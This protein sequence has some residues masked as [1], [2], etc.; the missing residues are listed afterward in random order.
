[1]KKYLL[2]GA[3]AVVVLG[4]GSAWA[5]AGYAAKSGDTTL[6]QARYD[7][8]Q[9]TQQTAQRDAPPLE[10]LG[11]EPAAGEGKRRNYFQGAYI[12][13]DIGYNFGS[14]EN[15]NGDVGLDGFLANGF[16]GYGYSFGKRD[17]IGGYGAIELAY[18]WDEADGNIGAQDYDKDHAWK[19]MLKPGVVV[20]GNAAGYGI[21][22]YSRGEFESGSDDE[23]LDGLILG[24]G[25]EFNTRSPL[26]VRFEYTYTNY[27]DT[28]LNNVRFDGHES[29]ATVGALLRF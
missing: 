3:A 27:E 13:A 28:N 4:S 15:N 8:S 11:V 2:L 6:G 24:A 17:M 9:P 23:N 29:A 1:M 12:G 16:V 21:I 19:A 14:Y 25:M 5:Q 20:E 7:Y 22:G 10:I 26:R 18:E